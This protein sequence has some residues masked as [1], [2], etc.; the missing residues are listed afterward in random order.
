MIGKLT[1]LTGQVQQYWMPM[2]LDDFMVAQAINSQ[3]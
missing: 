3:G 1:F 2:L